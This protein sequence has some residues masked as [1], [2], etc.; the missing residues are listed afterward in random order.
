MNAVAPGLIESNMT[1]A[2]KGVEAL[3][4]PEMAR[5]PMG[6]W[7][8]PEDVAPAFLFLASPDARFITGQTLCVD[9]GYSAN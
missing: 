4:A 7:G 2:M 3:E 5:T 6:R 9:G 1:R 8:M